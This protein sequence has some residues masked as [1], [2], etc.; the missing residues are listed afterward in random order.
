M[1]SKSAFKKAL[2]KLTTTVV[3]AEIAKGADE[4]TF[5]ALRAESVA[6]RQ[7]LISA[8]AALSAELGGSELPHQGWFEKTQ[9]RAEALF[10][11]LS[12]G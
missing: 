9:S 12:S 8:H 10:G 5:E 3:D 4:A 11:P 7:A 6:Q 2:Q 1:S